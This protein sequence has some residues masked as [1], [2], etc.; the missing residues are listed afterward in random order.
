[1]YVTRVCESCGNLAARLRYDVSFETSSIRFTIARLAR[2]AWS[3]VEVAEANNSFTS[4]VMLP[5]V[6]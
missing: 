5:N 3:L 6:R 4:S 2:R 1:M